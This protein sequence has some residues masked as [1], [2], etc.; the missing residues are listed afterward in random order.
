MLP[1]RDFFTR[2]TVLRAGRRNGSIPFVRWPEDLACHMRGIAACTRNASSVASLLPC[3]HQQGRRGVF[4]VYRQ[5]APHAEQEKGLSSCLFWRCTGEPLI[6][7]GRNCP[8]AK[9]SLA[10][11]H[12]SLLLAAGGTYLSGLHAAVVG[13]EGQEDPCTRQAEIF[14]VAAGR[15]KGWGHAVALTT[16]CVWWEKRTAS[17]TNK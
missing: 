5:V 9:A 6:C 11:S 16:A 8:P 1:L 17:K 12:L 13:Q 15:G 3:F 10:L 7:R 2:R 4:F 14:S